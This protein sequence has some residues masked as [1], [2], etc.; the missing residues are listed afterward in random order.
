MSVNHLKEVQQ[1]ADD[2]THPGHQGAGANLIIITTI[3][4]IITIIKVPTA[5]FLITVGNISAV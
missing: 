2:A 4:I 1:E 3:T 5:W